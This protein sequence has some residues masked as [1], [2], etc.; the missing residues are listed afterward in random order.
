[1]L[2]RAVQSVNKVRNFTNSATGD[3]VD[4]PVFL[5]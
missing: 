5:L 3:I 1:M 4:T 2:Q